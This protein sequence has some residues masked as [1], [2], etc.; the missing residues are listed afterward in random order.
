MIKVGLIA[1][2]GTITKPHFERSFE[3]LKSFGFEVVY[4]KSIFSKATGH[5]CNGL[6]FNEIG[7]KVDEIEERISFQ[8]VINNAQIRG[9]RAELNIL[10][11]NIKNTSHPQKY[12]QG[13]A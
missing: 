2:S 5:I 4:S 12:R 11:G 3:R 9:K 6:P 7:I 10:M 8:P 1:A 13:R